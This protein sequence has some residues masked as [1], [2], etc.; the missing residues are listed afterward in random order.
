MD[1][2]KAIGIWLVVLEHMPFG[3]S[4][5]IYIKY[6]K[7]SDNFNI[8]DFYIGS[9]HTFDKEEISIFIGRIK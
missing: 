9:I 1:W 8:Y 4:H 2:A 7:F 5:I 3:G 6:C